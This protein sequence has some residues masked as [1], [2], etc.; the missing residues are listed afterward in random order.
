MYGKKP[1]MTAEERKAAKAAKQ[2]RWK[3]KGKTEAARR[4]AQVS[5]DFAACVL[6]PDAAKRPKQL[7]RE[8]LAT[9]HAT[10]KDL[11]LEIKELKK[12][13]KAPKAKNIEHIQRA[14]LFNEM[15]YGL[16][17][18]AI[19]LPIFAR[20]KSEPDGK[21]DGWAWLRRWLRDNLSQARA[22]Q[23]KS[24]PHPEPLLMK[25]GPE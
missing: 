22:L 20:Y 21:T 25:R 3:E 16:K 19:N 8:K 17:H 18:V 24:S 2:K 23:Y 11:R 12:G 15:Y 10:V 14:R 1:V 9:V 13:E 4:A 5:Q 7:M 6:R